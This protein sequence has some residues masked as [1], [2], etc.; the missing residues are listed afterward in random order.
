MKKKV[1]I[2]Y[3]DKYVTEFEQSNQEEI[4]SFS[5]ANDISYDNAVKK[6]AKEKF[7][8]DSKKIREEA[9]QLIYL[10]I[11]KEKGISIQEAKKLVEQKR[12][13]DEKLQIEIVS[14]S[15]KFNFNEKII[16]N[17]IKPTSA[18]NKRRIRYIIRHSM[19][20]INRKYRDVFRLMYDKKRFKPSK[21]LY[22]IYSNSL[23]EISRLR[24]RNSNYYQLISDIF[25]EYLNKCYVVFF[26]YIL[27]KNNELNHN[28]NNFTKDQLLKIIINSP[29]LVTFM[30]DLD[31]YEAESIKIYEDEFETT[32]DMDNKDNDS[33]PVNYERAIME[34]LERG[35]G[36][37]FGLE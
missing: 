18:E 28:R 25:K 22:R 27:T 23:S 35:E 32:Y 17:K 19:G 11:S 3:W 6:L 30:G 26:E 31:K 21:K 33:D 13:V 37:L 29:L 7:D 2:N 1:E 34:A 4:V 16:T 12:A 15:L 9:N 10:H 8:T 20:E 36:D 5:E 14:N 24:Y